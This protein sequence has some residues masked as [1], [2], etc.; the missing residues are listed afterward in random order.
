MTTAFDVP[1]TATATAAGA[2]DATGPRGTTAMQPY[3]YLR[4]ELVEPDWRRFPGWASVTEE[5][6]RS[7]QWQR[8]HCVKS[9]K[10]LRV[11]MGDLLDERFYADLDRDQRERATMSMLV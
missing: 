2:A 11:L 7:A 4:T 1:P 3:A 6:W 10:Q 5:E 9:L 8:A